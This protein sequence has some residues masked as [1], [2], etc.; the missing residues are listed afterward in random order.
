M[1]EK[2]VLSL[3]DEA[4]DDD[5]EQE[6]APQKKLD[7]VEPKKDFLKDNIASSKY[8]RDD[9]MHSDSDMPL[10]TSEEKPTSRSNKTLDY[11][12]CSDDS[13]SASSDNDNDE[14]DVGSQLLVF[15][16]KGNSKEF[17]KLVSAHPESIK[18]KDKHG[19]NSLHWCCVRGNDDIITLAINHIK[20]NNFNVEKIINAKEFTSG[21]TPMHVSCCYSIVPFKN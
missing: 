18:F 12:K 20:S 16:Y 6:N 17:G 8:K 7:M 4:Y 14:P 13:D 19:W 10:N 21:F 5:F 1:S 3:N 2:I 9:D 11:D 15:A